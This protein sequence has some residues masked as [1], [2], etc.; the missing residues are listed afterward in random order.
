MQNEFLQK[1]CI[2]CQGGESPLTSSRVEEYLKEVGSN[3]F[4]AENETKIEREFTFKD[5]S[6]AMKF[7]D[8]VAKISEE[9]EHHPDIHVHYNKVKLVLWTH[10][11]GG[12]H[13]NDFIL[14]AKINELI[15]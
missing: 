14:A 4:I 8:R 3:W 10:A 2:P 9:E 13:E 12:L 5:F 6:E 1:K 15:N 11:I 7:V